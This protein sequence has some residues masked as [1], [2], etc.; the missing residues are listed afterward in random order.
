MRIY[1]LIL[2]LLRVD[3]L[4]YVGAL[5]ILLI[6]TLVVALTSQ[7]FSIVMPVAYIFVAWAALPIVLKVIELIYWV[8]YIL[9][10]VVCFFLGNRPPM[11]YG[12][13]D[14]ESNR[15]GAM[16][17]NFV[18]EQHKILAAV[19]LLRNNPSSRRYRKNLISVVNTY[20]KSVKSYSDTLQVHINEI[21][22]TSL[23]DKVT[24]Q[25]AAPLTEIQNFYYVRELI[26]INDQY[27]VGKELSTR[28]STEITESL[29]G[30]I[31][32]IARARDQVWSDETR[33]LPRDDELAELLRSGAVD[34]FADSVSL[35]ISA[36]Q[37]KD[38][39]MLD[40]EQRFDLKNR[41]VFLVHRLGELGLIDP[42][43][44]REYSR[45]F[46]KLIDHI[47]GL[48]ERVIVTSLALDNMVL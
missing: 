34:E 47:G 5:I 26:Q 23:I 25:G 1:Q 7:P 24:A 28:E 31:S 30:L 42:A 45:D 44:A 32:Q 29:N 15:Y 27:K 39:E 35:M 9:A 41:L 16:L 3:L 2:R 11:L 48:Q 21:E 17:S 19:A 13:K 38:E 46:I 22:I 40:D 20:N 14:V 33:G 10:A 36:L 18:C 37:S 8:L 6:A 4:L 43:M 12:A